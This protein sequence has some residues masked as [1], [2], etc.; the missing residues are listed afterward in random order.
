M[1]PRA[2]DAAEVHDESS[3]AVS[4]EI[5][6][7]TRPIVRGAR[8]VYLGGNRHKSVPL[9][10]KIAQE[11]FGEETVES[12]IDSG[13]TAY[14]FSTHDA[15]GRVIEARMMPATH[16]EPAVRGK[17]F[18]D[19]QHPDHLWQFSQ[20]RGPDGQP[21][22]KVVV[23]RESVRLVEEYFLAQQRGQRRRARE[24]AETTAH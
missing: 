7:P 2:A 19:C 4:S 3:V 11:R 6:Q 21:D 5:T 10:G 9:K 22:F 20:R 18:V 1:S 15:R 23:P 12:V 13:F 8:V 17:P 14:D 16:K 24:L